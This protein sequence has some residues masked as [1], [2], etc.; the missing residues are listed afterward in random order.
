[1]APTD[2]AETPECFEEVAIIGL[3][4]RFPGAKN[5]EQFWQNLRDGVEALSWFSDHDLA[6]H[7]PPHIR[8]APNYVKAG[9]ILDDVEH[10]DAAFFEVSPRLAQLT[11]PQQRLF[12]ECAWEALEHAGL[13]VSTYAGLIGLFAGASVSSYYLHHLLAAESASVANDLQIWLGNDK[14]YLAT[15]TAYKLNLQ[16]PCLTVQTA[17]STGLVAVHLACQSLLNYECD[18]ALAGGVTVKV[19]QKSGYFYEENAIFSP[20]GHCR[21]FDAKAQ[22]T[23]FGSGLGLVVLKR[24]S[25]ALEDRDP[26]LAVIKGSAINND[27]S[28]KVGYT[29]PSLNG[30]A[31][32]IA[33][34]ITVAR[35]EPETIT[36]IE[37]HGTGTPIGDPIEIAAL[38]Q[39]FK[40]H[41][42]RK[43]FCAL[44]SVK[45]NVGHLESAAGI[46]GLIKT[47]LALQHKL[48]PP[49]LYFDAPN[50]QIDFDNSPFYV[51]TRLVDWKTDDHPRRA[52]VSSFGMGGTNAHIV[53]EEAPVPQ[54]PESR[55]RRPLHVLTLSAKTE[56][57]LVQR[58]RQYQ[59][60]L[61]I[62]PS[63]NLH[64]ICFTANTGRAHFQHRAAVLAATPDEAREQLLALQTGQE[65]SR[66]CRGTI[67]P[68]QPPQV[69]FLF[70]GQ[71][72]QYVDMGRQLYDTQSTFREAL[73]RCDAILRPYLEPSLLD[74]LYPERRDAAI[75]PLPSALDRTAYTQPALFALEYALAALWQSWGVT[76]DVVMG[77]SVG[78]VTAACVAGVL[79]LED[80]LTLVAERSRLMQ[81]LPQNG[82][83]VVV[84][85]DE[86]RMQSAIQPEA[87][88]VSIA[89]I[90]GP[91]NVVISGQ[92]EAVQRI[93]TQLQADGIDTR[94]LTVSHAFHSPLMEPMLADFEHAIRHVAFAAPQIKLISNLTGEVA[95][96]EIATPAYWV[97]HVRQPV[98]FA[99]GMRTL[100]QQGY[101]LFVEIGP[102]PTLLGMGAQCLPEAPCRWLPSLRQGQSDWLP[103]LTSLAALYVQGVSV[104]WAG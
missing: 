104:D 42:E 12:L 10:F 36:Y 21:A 92:Q 38:A 30:Q 5:I 48:L 22:G 60:H 33:Q 27:G 83:M 54:A 74:V 103:L 49:S 88:R 6:A 39:V 93:V 78:E 20:D 52:G 15:Q 16:G 17:C 24:L 55:T 37:T 34:A 91:E 14:D 76:P 82:S 23:V 94:P 43:G 100:E 97:R 3:S 98:K 28:Q 18:V 63:P 99:A 86:D 62:Q 47:V 31:T 59:D 1:M 25:Q 87:R 53:L 51:N 13:D 32:V 68:E 101:R 71:G 45:T 65:V 7:Y 11:D 72:V 2:I 26:I 64:D 58:A 77:H 69:A 66:A 8:Q 96:D 40:A 4:G 9:F 35:V 50:P 19:P 73:D 56:S 75:D 41:T 70:T 61:A 102:Q 67:E 81:A 89:A 95:P 44:G 29:A 79:S 90:N 80:G 57:A 85:A 46:A 84:R